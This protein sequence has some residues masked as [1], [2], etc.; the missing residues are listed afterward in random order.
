MLQFLFCYAGDALTAASMGVFMISY[1]IDVCHTELPAR[2][3]ASRP[4]HITR[5]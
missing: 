4:S 1:W 5:E 3:R 2:R